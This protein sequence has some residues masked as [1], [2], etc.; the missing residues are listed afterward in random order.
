MMLGCK[1]ILQLFGTPLMM[2]LNRQRY[3]T[4]PPQKR[5]CRGYAPWRP[6]T[7][8]EEKLLLVGRD[9]GERPVGILC[10]SD[11]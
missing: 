2:V 8:I 7:I 1:T 11:G 9:V 10:L 3:A 4:D 6:L 5:S